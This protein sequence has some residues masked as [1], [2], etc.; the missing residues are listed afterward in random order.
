MNE[1]V[2]L[3]YPRS[4]NHLCRFFIELLTELPTY[5]CKHSESDVEIYKNTFKEYIPFNIPN[6]FNKSKCFFKYHISVT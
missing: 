3:S 4:G 5:G 6:K 1:N 2:L